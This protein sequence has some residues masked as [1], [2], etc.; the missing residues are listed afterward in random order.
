MKLAIPNIFLFRITCV[1]FQ[2]TFLFFE[3]IFWNYCFISRNFFNFKFFFWIIFVFAEK[4]YFSSE[5]IFLTIWYIWPKETITI[6]VFVYFSLPYQYVHILQLI[7]RTEI[8][9]IRHDELSNLI[10][11]LFRIWKLYWM[12]GCVK[13]N[14]VCRIET[15]EQQTFEFAFHLGKDAGMK[16]VAVPTSKFWIVPN[17][18]QKVFWT[19]LFSSQQR[20]VYHQTLSKEP[21]LHHLLY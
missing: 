1:N 6:R 11:Y 15:P 4:I 18:E 10:Y 16:P 21:T 7:M 8:G 13:L 20:G 5:T 2:I 12:N 19:Y 14:T 17:S 3:Y 9:K